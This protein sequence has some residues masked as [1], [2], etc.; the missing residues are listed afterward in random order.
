MN[1]ARSIGAYVTAHTNQAMRKLNGKVKDRE[2]R[3][4]DRRRPRRAARSAGGGGRNREKRPDSVAHTGAA[5]GLSDRIPSEPRSVHGDAPAV[6]AA[7]GAL[8]SV[9]PTAP[10]R[11][12]SPIKPVSG[13]SREQVPPVVPEPVTVKKEKC[14]GVKS[15]DPDVPGC[16]AFGNGVKNTRNQLIKCEY[17]HCTFRKFCRNCKEGRNTL[18]VILKGKE[19][20]GVSIEDE[21]AKG[22][23]RWYC[24]RICSRNDKEDVDGDDD[25]P[26]D[27]DTQVRCRSQTSKEDDEPGCGRKFD[28]FNPRESCSR[29]CGRKKFC[30]EC[31]NGIDENR[32]KIEPKGHKIYDRKLKDGSYFFYCSQECNRIAEEEGE[33]VKSS[34][35][36]ISQEPP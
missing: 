31:M 27:N 36:M 6:D 7:T 9:R 11:P 1:I 10:G 15:K 23:V 18:G 17:Q 2:K 20:K 4:K 26:D 8:G 34:G 33:I 35:R 32:R 28:L 12:V 16:G 30:S 19:P 25:D 21:D 22:G 29:D 14:R 3:R 13:A 5:I 24:S